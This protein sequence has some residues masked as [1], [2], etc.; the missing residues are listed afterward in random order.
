MWNSFTGDQAL[1]DACVGIVYWLGDPTED[2]AILKADYP[3]CNHGLIVAL[4]NTY[5]NDHITWQ[6]QS[7]SVYE[8]YQKVKLNGTNYQSIV[9]DIRDTDQKILGYN[10]TQVLLKYNNACI[11][12]TEVIPANQ[13]KN[14][15][16]INQAPQNSSGWFLPSVTEMLLLANDSKNIK[17]RE[18]NV[19]TSSQLNNIV[20]IIK[21][22]KNAF[23][24]VNGG[25]IITGVLYDD[26]EN[27][28]ASTFWYWTSSEYNDGGIWQ[29]GFN[30][31]YFGA[32]EELFNDGGY[33]RPVCAF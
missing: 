10:N 32:W 4:D 21:E 26:S 1:I 9:L 29:V 19:Y 18:Q 12:G 25:D 30:T 31:S 33:I 20:T 17:P 15:A 23:I 27:E 24:Q 7:L 11:Y 2:D 28:D 14:F 13:V 8:N 5:E 16:D 6:T 22:L 3:D